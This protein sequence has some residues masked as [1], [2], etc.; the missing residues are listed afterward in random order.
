LT[1]AAL[2]RVA[3]G[4][5]LYELAEQQRHCCILHSAATVSKTKH[6]APA[7]AVRVGLLYGLAQEQLLLLD[8]LLLLSLL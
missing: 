2:L 5:L 7:P 3:P 1:S 6:I 8:L 4:G